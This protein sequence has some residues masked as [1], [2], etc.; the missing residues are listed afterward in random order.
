[1]YVIEIPTN[2]PVTIP[3]IDNTGKYNITPIFLTINTATNN[4]PIL[5]N[6]PPA[7]LTPIIETLSL[8]NSLIITIIIKLKITEARCKH[9]RFVKR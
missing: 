1:M 6:T 8:N 7:A 4:C 9:T 5:W 2:I 3:A